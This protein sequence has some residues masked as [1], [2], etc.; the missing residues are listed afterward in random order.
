MFLDRDGTLIV[1]RRYLGDPDGVELLPSAANAV[2]RLNEAS[3]AA[4]VITNQS[5][6]ARGF[7]DEG[8][9]Q[10]VRERLDSELASSGAKLDASFHCPHHP[11]VTGACECR[12]PGTLLHRNAVQS[13]GL[14][15]DRL[16]FVGDRWHDILPAVEMGG[17][18]V[19][20]TSPETPADELR[21]AETGAL[22]VPDVGAAVELIL[23]RWAL[24]G[25]AA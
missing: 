10:L 3:V 22:C 4:V 13:L 15:P 23:S 16:A 21:R 1:D 17:V 2:R 14:D 8:K 20:V 25:E 11:Q 5:G 12:K 6:I 9:Y 24:N 18:G 7:F 19:L